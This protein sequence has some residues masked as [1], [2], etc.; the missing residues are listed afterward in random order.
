MRM[1]CCRGGG[2]RR[3]ADRRGARAIY[4]PLRFDGV[5]RSPGPQSLA[6][7]ANVEWRFPVSANAFFQINLL[8]WLE[9]TRSVCLSVSQSVPLYVSLSASLLVCLQ[10]RMVISVLRLQ[11]YIHEFYGQCLLLFVCFFCSVSSSVRLEIQIQG[12]F[13][14]KTDSKSQCIDLTP[15]RI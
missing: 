8:Q 14:R 11:L 7:L 2:W 1:G 13:A 5:L 10:C 15:S 4:A 3:E 6:C 9:D 12:N